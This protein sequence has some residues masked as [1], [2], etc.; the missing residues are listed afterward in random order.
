MQAAVQLIDRTAAT[1][2]GF[3]AAKS[4]SP[5]ATA[6]PEVD[7][8]AQV[9]NLITATLAYDANARVLDAQDATTRAAIDLVV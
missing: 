4:S 3:G 1:T 8:A 6:G 2:A 5:A 7:L 9:T